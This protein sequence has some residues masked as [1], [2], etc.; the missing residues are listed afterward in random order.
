[1][2]ELPEGERHPLSDH[3]TDVILFDDYAIAAERASRQR[4]KNM[5]QA[6]IPQTDYT[7]TLR[8]FVAPPDPMAPKP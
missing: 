3:G 2:T 5:V 4:W 7:N 1:M 8:D 6:G